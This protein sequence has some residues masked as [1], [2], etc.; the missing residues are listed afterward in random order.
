MFEIFQYSFMIR[1]F[2]AGMVIAVVA[3]MIGTFLVVRRYS[4]ISDT[5]SHVSFAGVMAG[6]LFG[7]HPLLAALV[8]T[9]VAA[10]VIE[11]IR[12]GKRIS[13]ETVL[14]LFLSGGL[15]VAVVLMSLGRSFTLDLFS[16]LFGS[17]ATVTKQDLYI[18]LP[19]GLLVV[20]LVF[21]LF[22]EFLYVSF[23]EEGAEVNGVPVMV[24]NVV[25]ILL[26][27]VTIVVSMRIIGILLIG[28]LLTIPSV[29][30]MQLSKSFKATV[31]LAV[32]ISLFSVIAGLFVSYYLNIPAGGA[33]VL[34]ALSVFGAVAILTKNKV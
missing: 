16:Y 17:I 9:G 11:K 28:A 22:K 15:A 14:S 19:L 21:L 25:L 20:G 33:V 34:I 29:T 2:I 26:A 5:L 13:A 8:I 30:A 12:T 18:I 4:L 3:P 7:I 6:L 27:A 24:L 10:L 32:V 1:A 23:D 31:A